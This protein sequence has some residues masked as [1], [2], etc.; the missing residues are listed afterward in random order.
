[1]AQPLDA[2]LEAYLHASSEAAVSAQLERLAARAEPVIRGVIRRRWPSSS[3]PRDQ[4][5]VEDLYG[6][7][8]IQLLTRLEEEREQSTRA[9]EAAR[10]PIRDFPALVA[11]ITSRTCDGWLRR[12]FPERARLKRRLEYLLSGEGAVREFAVWA[13]ADGRRLAG[14]RDWAPSRTANPIS[15]AYRELVE[16]PRASLARALGEREPAEIHP[17]DLLTAVLRLAGGPM[18]LDDLV[19]VFAVLWGVVDQPETPLDTE[20]S[21]QRP[22]SQQPFDLIAEAEM[23]RTLWGEIRQ[24]PPHHCAAL[25]LNLRDP[26]GHGVVGLLPMRQI[27]SMSEIARAMGMEPL[28]L[29][30]IWNGLPLDDLTIAEMLGCSRQQVINYRRSAR[31]R[32]AR[33][34]HSHLVES[35]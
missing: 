29:A 11:T 20:M 31:E 2:S 27:A 18:L 16:S 13:G 23:L 3:S 25:L 19:Q 4:Q 33:R 14:M 28:R 5:S 6:E 32:L 8:M 26:S 30:E 24:L 35:R 1:M 7:A 9:S 22:G 15:R 21:Q 34:M 12:R 10:A 17:A